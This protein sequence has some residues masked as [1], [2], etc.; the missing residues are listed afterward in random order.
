LCLSSNVLIS[1]FMLDFDSIIHLK[2]HE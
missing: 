1:V 2:L